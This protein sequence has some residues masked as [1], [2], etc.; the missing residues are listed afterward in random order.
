MKISIII[1]IYNIDDYLDRCMLSV[2]TQTYKN[3]QIICV[4]DGSTDNSLNIL[5]KYA[6]ED[7]RIIIVNKE[8]GGLP[9]AR[10]A[11][12]EI[13]DGDFIF[14]LDGDDFI[15]N[16]AIESLVNKQQGTGADIV[17]GDFVYYKN[18][19]SIELFDKFKFDVLPG[20]DFTKLLL[21]IGAFFIWGKIIRRSINEDIEIPLDIQYT[22]DAI[23]MIQLAIKAKTVAKINKTCYYYVQRDNAFT[24]TLSKQNFMQWYR[25]T[26]FVENYLT[27]TNTLHHV[28]E[29]F[30]TYKINQILTYLQYT[31]I[32]G[33]YRD[34]ISRY[35]RH[36]IT[37]KRVSCFTGN[38]KLMLLLA[39]ISQRLSIFEYKIYKSIRS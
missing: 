1:P 33:I 5:Q 21:K 39:C 18:N 16:D 29:E 10:K 37:A 27:K 8:N 11:G 9:S 19:K 2:I 14:H 35:L 38:Q 7:K 17:L 15:P 28:N 22:E 34:D 30:I 25:S 36:T 13:A 23:A 31:S 20:I 3:L 6:D 32:T 4:N 12:L 24:S 26:L